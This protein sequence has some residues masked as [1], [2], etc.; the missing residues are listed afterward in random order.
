MQI[1]FLYFCIY[2]I[3]K[4]MLNN[5]CLI[6]G[7]NC[8]LII[9]K[10][11]ELTNN[12]LYDITSIRQQVFVVE[13]DCAFIDSDGFDKLAVHII[14]VNPQGNI[15]AYARVL[16]KNIIYKQAT[17]GRVL[18]HKEYRKKG[19]GKQLFTICLDVLETYFGKQAIK[20]QAQSYLV[21]FYKTFGFEVLNEA[22]LDTGIYHNDMIK[23]V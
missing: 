17:I 22:Y 14:I 8:S 15:I 3:Y 12:E 19:L 21:D 10:F 1:S 20:I 18:T 11:T 23:H 9:K 2:E 5:S 13:Q 16:D 6:D 7:E 4:Y